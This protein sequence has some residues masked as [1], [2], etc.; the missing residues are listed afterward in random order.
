VM[1]KDINRQLGLT[2]EIDFINLNRQRKRLAF[3]VTKP[4]EKTTVRIDITSGVAEL[5]RQ[6]TGRWD[7]TIYLHKMPGPHNASVRGNWIFMRLW[8]WLA[9]ASVYLI[10][11]ATA[12]GIY[13]WIALK[14]ERRIGMICLGSGAL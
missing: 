14:A 3:P 5:E 13:L 10:L 2:G 11:F 12:S 6:V 1:A 8:G 7:A 4:G 9:D